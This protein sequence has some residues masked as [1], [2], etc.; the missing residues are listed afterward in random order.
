MTRGGKREGAGRPPAPDKMKLYSYKAT[1]PEH[2]QMEAN[3][4]ACGVSLSEF[5]RRRC[6]DVEPSEGDSL[7]KQT[8]IPRK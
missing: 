6:L 5:I 4:D 3:A 2:E 1:E 7:S 8:V